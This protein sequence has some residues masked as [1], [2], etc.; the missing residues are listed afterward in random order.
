[1]NKYLKHYQTGVIHGTRR[2]VRYRMIVGCILLSAVVNNVVYPAIYT[3]L[4]AVPRY[5]VLVKS[6]EDVA[7][8]QD[9]KVYVT[10]GSFTANY[11]T[12][13]LYLKT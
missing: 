4:L 6:I 8:N 13:S 10:R 5:K 9:M 2:A 12:V 7:A 1:M 11:V 3:S